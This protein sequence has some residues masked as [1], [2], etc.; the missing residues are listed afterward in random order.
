MKKY[1]IRLLNN[2]DW[3]QSWGVITGEWEECLEKGVGEVWMGMI[4]SYW[5]M[6]GNITV[7]PINISSYYMLVK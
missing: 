1:A 5:F 6:Y 2:F 3:K 4:S 7:N